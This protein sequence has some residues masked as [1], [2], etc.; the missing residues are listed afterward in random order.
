MKKRHAVPGILLIVLLSLAA[1]GPRVEIDQSIHPVVLP[2]DLDTYLATAESRY[3]DIRPGTEKTIRW[4][5]PLTRQKTPYAL[6]YLHGFA[7]SR[8]EIAP[9]PDQLAQRLGAN[10]YY[11]RLRGHGRDADAMAE[12]S[13]NDWLNEGVEAL[14]IGRRLGE[15]L[16]IIGTSTGGTLASWLALRQDTH[17][18]LAFVLVSP[19][20]WPKD[21]NAG[22]LLWP[23]GQAIS[24]LAI[25]NYKSFKPANEAMAKYWTTT[26]RTEALLTM[27]GLV[28]LVDN[29]DFTAFKTPVLVL[30]SERDQIVN[31]DKIVERFAQIASPHKAL[32]V[33][34]DSGHS[35]HHVIAG[36]VLSPGTNDW[37]VETML[38]FIDGLPVTRNE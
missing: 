8:Q 6:V 24:Q 29:A 16:I 7:S 35:K 30:Y 22:F 28:S 37:A 13:V 4:A 15:K 25:G 33:M 34:N 3:P 18:I 38:N 26:Y 14:E 32:Q 9:V 21:D 31:P 2:A 23:W 1:L 12:P 5:D 19:N 11:H 27:M 20:F 17:N 36:D 10:L